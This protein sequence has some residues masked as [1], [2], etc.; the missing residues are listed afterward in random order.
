MNSGLNDK[1]QPSSAIER[2]YSKLKKK[3][4]I[5]RCSQAR[6][7]VF[8][9]YGLAWCILAW[10][11]TFGMVLIFWFGFVWFS[12]LPQTNKKQQSEQT[13]GLTDR[14]THRP[15]RQTDGWTK[16]KKK[17]N[18]NGTWCSQAVTHPSTNQARRCL[19]SVIGRE[20]VCST[21]YG[22]WQQF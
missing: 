18:A 14:R 3:S 1:N 17:K 11:V 20:P 7:G 4:N 5:T 9:R 15:R 16:K 13:D 12:S 21:W 2:K 19:T 6:T 8:S 10:P 22:R